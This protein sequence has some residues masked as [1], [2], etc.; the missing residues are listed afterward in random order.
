MDGYLD[1]ADQREKSR[2]IRETPLVVLGAVIA[3]L[4]VIV[5]TAIALFA[6]RSPS[7]E[8]LTQ[9]AIVAEP[10]ATVT[11]T[12]TAE[13]TV[14][15]VATAT[16]VVSPATTRPAT[17]QP[18]TTPTVV[19]EPEA[20]TVAEDAASGDDDTAA[21]TATET[22]R[23]QQPDERQQPDQ[24]EEASRDGSLLDRLPGLDVVPEGFAITNEGPLTIEQAADLHPD[25]EAQL[26][27]LRDWGFRDAA[28]REFQPSSEDSPLT[29]LVVAVV[30]FGSPE[31]ARAAVDAGH[32]EVKAVAAGTDAADA[33]VTDAVIERIGDYSLAAEGTVTIEGQ[34]IAAAYVF[35]QDGS[36][37]YSIVGL[38]PSD[39]GS[40]LDVVTDV[41]LTISS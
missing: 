41:A 37:A 3:F 6:L 20:T 26:Q 7:D 4:L 35:V 30:D 39:A 31:Q 2:S 5:A 32:A 27:R 14:T 21:D 24:S 40:P 25:P 23:Q 38:A 33:T 28:R 19:D 18:T 34:T 1:D 15:T 9:A 17:Q 13:T 11:P 10:S 22:D 16:A 12:S 36:L 29:N 8:P